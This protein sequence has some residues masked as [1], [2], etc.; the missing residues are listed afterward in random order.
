MLQAKRTSTAWQRAFKA[1][2]TWRAAIKCVAPINA[3]GMRE[4]R[5]EELLGRNTAVGSP[6]QSKVSLRIHYSCC[7]TPLKARY[8][9]HWS[10]YWGPLWKRSERTYTLH[11]LLL[12]SLNA[13]RLAHDI[14]YFGALESRVLTQCICCLVPLQSRIPAYYNCCWVTLWKHSTE[15]WCGS[16][17]SKSRLIRNRFDR[18]FY[19]V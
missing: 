2:T 6:F 7:W 18:Q 15:W 12:A 9:T 11:L 13:V 16:E 5:L 1:K 4:T 19:P 3:W 17:N 10:C 8:F 14:C